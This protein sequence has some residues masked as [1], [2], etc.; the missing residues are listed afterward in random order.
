[1]KSRKLL[2]LITSVVA[3]LALTGCM[4]MHEDLTLHSDNTVSG[5]II[6]AYDVAVLEMSGMSEE[7]VDELLAAEGLG[8]LTGAGDDSVSISDYRDGGYVG[9]KMEF[10]EMPL[11]DLASESGISIIREGDEFVVEADY[12][13]IEADLAAVPANMLASMD[14]RTTITFPG[15]VI[16]QRGGEVEGNT[17][18]WVTNFQDLGE[19][20][21]RAHAIEGAGAGAPLL[22]IG[23]GAG[24]LVLLG[25]VIFLLV[26]GR[27]KQAANLDAAPFA[28]GPYATGAY[29][30]E[31]Y[32]SGPYVAAPD[33]AGPGYDPQLPQS[34]QVPLSTQPPQPGSNQD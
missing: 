16:E 9:F 6:M 30:G 21:G 28:A 32:G 10:T 33:G 24:L 1:M 17:V 27:K 18:T 12:S 15:A 14:M 13:T 4:R 2:A 25:I 26:R 31:P 8:D 7:D 20:Y 23:A 5:S 22:L 29:G 3:L 34:R 19:V 11:E